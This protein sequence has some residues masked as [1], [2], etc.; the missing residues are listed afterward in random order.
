MIPNFDGFTPL[1]PESTL[2]ID[3][4]YE[5]HSIH[6]STAPA[7]VYPEDDDKLHYISWKDV[8]NAINIG[9]EYIKDQIL[10]TIPENET[11]RE[12]L[13]VGVLS[14]ADP[15]TFATFLLSNIRLTHLTSTR[16]ILPFAI[17]PRNSATAVAHLLRLKQVKHV[18]VT[19]GPMR[20]L[21]DEAMKDLKPEEVP[22]GFVFP[23]YE[24]LYHHGTSK[25]EG[26][27]ILAPIPL[28][29][30]AIILHSSGS[31]AFPKPI[32]ITHQMLMEWG[33]KAIQ[34][35][36]DFRGHTLGAQNGPMFHSMGWFHTGWAVYTGFIR[37]VQNP[38]SG[39]PSSDP[40]SFLR[41]M[42]WANE[43]ENIKFLKPLKTIIFGGAPLS[44]RTGK[45]LRSQGVNLL[46][47]YGST[48]I[49]DITHL[50]D[51][52]YPEGPEWF[53]LPLC[54]D[55]VLIPDH[56]E[57]NLFEIAFKLAK[58]HHLAVFNTEID[59]VPAY[60]TS[61]LVERHPNNH[62]L[63]RIRGRIDDQ[64]VL[65][66]GEKN[67]HVKF[68]VVFGRGRTSNGVIIEPTSFDEAERLGL[69]KFRSLIWPSVEN[70]N[71]FAP[72]HSR[73]FK[74]MII[75]ASRS[76]PFVYTAKNTARRGAVIKE[77]DD[78]I[79][80][81]YKEVENSAQTDVPLPLEL[82]EFGGWS[83]ETTR[84]F[85]REVV[86]LIMKDASNMRDEDDFFAYGCDSLQATYIRNI[87][88]NALRKGSSSSNVQNLPNNLVYQHPT[89]NALTEIVSQSS[90][91]KTVVGELELNT[92][93]QKRLQDFIRKYTQNWPKHK[94]G[95]VQGPYPEVILLT[96]STGSLGSQIFAELI[97]THSVRRIYAFNRPSSKTLRQRHIE[98]FADRGNDLS[99]LDSDKIVYVE[100]DT[101]AQNLGI[102]PEL[103]EQVDFNIS[104]VS[105]EQTVRGVR[106]LI[107]LALVSPHTTTPRLL[108]TSSIGNVK[109]WAN[110]SAVPES[111][112]KNVD[113]VN[114]TG[115]NESKWISEQIL[116]TASVETSLEPV[117]VRVG[118]L[119]GGINGNWNIREWFP[120][121]VKVSEVLK[122][123]PEN[124]GVVSFIPL[125][126]AA[127]SL[128]ELRH[129]SST[130][131]NLVHP[132]PIP[133][134]KIINWVGERL[135]LSTV[136][137]QEWLRRL[138]GLP[139]TYET[140]SQNPA[141]HLLDFYRAA[142]TLADGLQD[143]QR[144]EAM[145]I[146]T[147][148]TTNTIINAFSLQPSYLPQ[149]T[150]DDVNRWIDYWELK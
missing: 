55:P 150:R 76:K 99:L 107:D 5:W 133:W 137:Y 145:G 93:R 42:A 72:S 67:P 37:S 63:F 3:Q 114:S 134:N 23:T 112:F 100:G 11:N 13:I 47:V 32:T 108:F 61:D 128:V 64:I 1:P 62:N 117:I 17:S 12:P 6:S 2:T 98:A 140:L 65:S 45:Y 15:L 44:E 19:E 40:E 20:H 39:T 109:L 105:F 132:N 84:N 95:S 90:R 111:S 74:E 48:E 49:G 85:V 119:C 54:T 36:F 66:I 7:F 38:F 22:T 147:Y 122:V 101:S 26:K 130:F 116:E 126:M 89:I 106:N 79:E 41:E 50:P 97:N 14:T 143:F 52:S 59:G 121:L 131:A 86:H 34:G 103:F 60:T 28:D 18:W 141:L 110:I 29:R 16:R 123:L 71:E 21:Y 149:L 56:E 135:N 113:L 88:L 81:L 120:A 9:A 30:P 91:P 94:P 33:I 53:R 83:F 125:H 87:M 46:M 35:D 70:A 27:D 104:L 57:P 148:E 43:P 124:E 68:A 75:L 24:E 142:A 115:Y 31:T 78:E 77:Y 136:P 127:K 146:A 25:S 8:G 80:S 139:R 102:D 138:E 51:Q 96:G 118:Q 10:Q 82:D 4:A 129:S 92:A 73:I 144:H 69:E 58:G